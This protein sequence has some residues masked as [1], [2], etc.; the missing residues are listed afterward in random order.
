MNGTRSYRRAILFAILPLGCSGPSPSHPVVAASPPPVHHAALSPTSGSPK[1][2]SSPPVALEKP[3]SREERLIARML[4]KVGHVRGLVP[5]KSVPGVTLGR[6]ALIARV[7]SH[8]DQ[9]VPHEAIVHEGLVQQLLGFI[10]PRFDYEAA[11]YALLQAQLA[12]FYEPAD[13][14][15]YMAADLDDE[16]AFATLAHELVHALQDQYWDLGPRS[17]YVPGQDDKT[18]AFSGLAEGDATSAM[19][20]VL[21][22]QAR[23]GTTALDIPEELF[24]EQIIGGMSGGPDHDTP[25][26][27]RMSLVAPYIDGTLFVHALRRKGGWAAVNRAWE[28]P[29]ETT[30]QLLH[31]DKWEKHEA[32][33]AVA[34]PSFAALGEGWSVADVDTYGELGLRLSLGEW[35]GAAP[36]SALAAGWGGDRI[37]LVKK[38]E[39]Y[40][41]GWHLRF[42]DARLDGT[43]AAPP[44]HGQRQ[45][46]DAYAARAFLALGPAVA[47]LSHGL[48]KPTGSEPASFVCIERHELGPLAVSR[49]GRDIVILAG[50]ANVSPK[51]WSSAGKCDV[52]RRWA[53]EITP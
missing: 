38:G 26:V 33:L 10:P 4:E 42:D 24:A 9:E 40:A 5:K 16:N 52:L 25:H 17:K 1:P 11:T 31:V 27:M 44:R 21:I 29:P 32:P 48:G 36:A 47:K 23:P 2:P 3:P 28:T 35:L 13:G 14:T 53:T 30:E 6:T 45:A 43:S 34:E 41:V 15:M 50:P 39:A 49:H 18:S 37:V 8:V 20:D 22:S 46:T 7:K 12:G 51:G 19:A